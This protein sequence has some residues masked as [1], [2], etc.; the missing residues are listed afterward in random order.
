MVR[1][2]PVLEKALAVNGI[3][4]SSERLTKA[5]GCGGLPSTA[6]GALQA[7]TGTFS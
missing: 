2:T 3:T 6:M 5:D 7:D 1:T 4:F